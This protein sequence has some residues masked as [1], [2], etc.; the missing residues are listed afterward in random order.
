MQRHIYVSTPLDTGLT[1]LRLHRAS[2]WT[3]QTCH[4]FYV[5]A[6]EHAH[7]CVCVCV[8]GG[9]CVR[10]CKKDT[11]EHIGVSERYTCVLES[12]MNNWLI[13]VCIGVWKSTPTYT[14]M[15]KK[16]T[17]V[18]IG[19]Q[20]LYTVCIGVQKRYTYMHRS[21]RE[22]QLHVCM[23]VQERYTCMYRCMRKVHLYV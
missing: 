19:V 16:S 18:W 4:T 17:Q 8:G 14:Q 12:Y 5:R 22:V 11:P 3:W 6:S 21:A 13:V 1:K 7:V 20:E 23:G 15:C 10:A 9:G 2:H